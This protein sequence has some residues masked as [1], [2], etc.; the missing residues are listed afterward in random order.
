MSTSC[1]HLVLVAVFA[2][3]ILALLVLADV[4]FNRYKSGSRNVFVVVL[5][6]VV[7]VVVVLVV[8][9]FTYKP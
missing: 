8:G 2:V 3:R 1:T 9:F 6:V 4:V 7:L 5:V